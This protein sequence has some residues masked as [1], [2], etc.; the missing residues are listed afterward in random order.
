MN[1]TPG[2]RWGAIEVKLDWRRSEEA[3]GSLLRLKAKLAGQL[4]D[5][6]FLMILT[7]TGGVAHTRD[8]GVHVVPLDC[9][10]P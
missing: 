7:A 10:G 9:L 6:S 1:T 4:A 8:D 3:A 2:G 5:P